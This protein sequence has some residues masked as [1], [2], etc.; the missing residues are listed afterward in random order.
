MGLGY[1]IS[2]MPKVFKDRI[3]KFRKKKNGYKIQ[4]ICWLGKSLICK[5]LKLGSL[6]GINDYMLLPNYKAFPRLPL[7]TNLFVTFPISH[8]VLSSLPCFLLI[9]FHP[10]SLSL[11][12][13]PC[14]LQTPFLPPA[15][16]DPPDV[17]IPFLSHLAL[18]QVTGKAWVSLHW[19]EN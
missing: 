9:S 11:C 16:V 15:A 4:H 17:S 12:F 13:L 6:L 14:D 19:L 2:Q 3:D 5:L 7:F 1:K 8:F 18:V 10:Y